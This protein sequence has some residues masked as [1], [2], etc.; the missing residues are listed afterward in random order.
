MIYK[1]TYAVTHKDE[2]K[3]PTNKFND[4]HENRHTQ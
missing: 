2:K 1:N 4:T 3:T